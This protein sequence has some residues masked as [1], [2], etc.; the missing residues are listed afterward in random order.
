MIRSMT[1]FGSARAESAQGSVTIEFRSVN[2][3]FLDIHFRLPEDLRMAEGLIRESLARHV[4][5]GKVE[6]R[7]NYARTAASTDAALDETLLAS[8]ASQLAVARRLIPDVPAP[9]LAELISAARGAGNTEAFDIDTWMAMCQQAT[10]Q[11]LVEMQAAR[12]REGQRLA[13]V[14]LDCAATCSTIV[15]QVETE[16]PTILAEHK[17]RLTDK[18]RD[19][20]ASVSPDGFERISGEELSARI[21]QEAALFSMRIDVAEELSRLRS[22]I[23]ELKHLLK[24][25]ETAAEGARKNSGSAGKR[26]DFLFQEMN[27]EANTLGS[28]ASALNV[29]RAAIDLKLQIEQ[30]REQAQNIE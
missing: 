30:M 28:K 13:S 25:G 3:R 27:R 21:A 12:E 9:T 23:T 20:L 4:K 6:V 18:L 2:S 7:L 10:E 15:E 8:A 14:M 22:H 11:A 17:N 16:L 19:A 29:T 26:L 24:T 5:R 1:S